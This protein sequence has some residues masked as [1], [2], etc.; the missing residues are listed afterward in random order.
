MP[1]RASKGNDRGDLQEK[2]VP[3]TMEPHTHVARTLKLKEGVSV[4]AHSFGLG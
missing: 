1:L 3:S 2:L 4:P